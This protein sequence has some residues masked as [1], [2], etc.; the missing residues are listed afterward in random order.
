MHRDTSDSAPPSH[1]IVR[2]IRPELEA[3]FALRRE[4]RESSRSRIFPISI[5]GTD[6][7]PAAFIARLVFLSLEAE[8]RPARTA[9]PHRADLPGSSAARDELV[10]RQKHSAGPGSPALTAA[11]AAR[12]PPLGQGSPDTRLSDTG[13]LSQ[14]PAP[15]PPVQGEPRPGLLT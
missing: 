6:G 12:G 8:S 1:Q 2:R 4:S 9:A 15:S 11:S 3:T 13:R 7:Q 14:P 10:E 5:P